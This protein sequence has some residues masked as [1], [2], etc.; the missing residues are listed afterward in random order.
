MP[1]AGTVMIDWYA[2]LWCGT[3]WTI[4][5]VHASQG[6]SRTGE[7]ERTYNRSA[8]AE[9]WIVF[10][11]LECTKGLRPEACASSGGVT[12]S[13]SVWVEDREKWRGEERLTSVW[14]SKNCKDVHGT[15]FRDP[16]V[17]VRWSL[18]SWLWPWASCR[19]CH[20]RRHVRRSP[21]VQTKSRRGWQARRR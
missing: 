17:I 11:R 6:T 9:M 14:T 4:P 20:G 18:S 10:F 13:R 8:L 5:G 19:G 16:V 1:H 7:C 21:A 3:R 15:R 2:I 12:M